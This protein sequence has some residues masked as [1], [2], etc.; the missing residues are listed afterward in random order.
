MK[1]G[2]Q[3][4]FSRELNFDKDKLNFS[5]LNYQFLSNSVS[6]DKGAIYFRQGRLL[7]NAIT[8]NF[9]DISVKILGL[10]LILLQGKYIFIKA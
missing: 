8:G 9:N 10:M 6:L 3:E 4:F 7:I 1:I 5:H 2:G